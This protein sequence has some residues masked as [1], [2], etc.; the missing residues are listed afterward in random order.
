[1]S[2][3][4]PAGGTDWARATAARPAAG[5]VV[6]LHHSAVGRGPDSPDLRR[7]PGAA[8][9]TFFS[10]RASRDGEARDLVRDAV[11]HRMGMGDRKCVEGTLKRLC[12]SGLIRR[13][14]YRSTPDTPDWRRSAQK[15]PNEWRDRS[16]RAYSLS[17][18]V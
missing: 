8:D 14:R 17:R 13:Y 5:N 2:P 9:G 11:F 12:W 4:H 1:M 16:C 7:P 10:E 18:L 3:A 15:P 6:V